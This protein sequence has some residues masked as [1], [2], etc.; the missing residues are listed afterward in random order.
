MIRPFVIIL[1]R[2]RETDGLSICDVKV[3][4]ILEVFADETIHNTKV[5]FVALRRSFRGIKDQRTISM[6]DGVTAVLELP[7]Q[8]TTWA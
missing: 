7:T 2:E 4:V 6:F 3:S 8:H 5:R 1:R